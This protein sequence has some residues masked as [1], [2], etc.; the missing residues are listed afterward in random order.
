MLAFSINQLVSVTIPNTVLT[1]GARAF[2]A[3]SL[4]A[5]LTL[6]NSVTTI[7]IRAF[8][9]NQLTNIVIPNNITSI[10]DYAYWTILDHV[11]LNI[12]QCHLA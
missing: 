8:R 12:R 10:D 3:N 6:G 4:L 5:N 2:D 7:G 1:I 11:L 9:N